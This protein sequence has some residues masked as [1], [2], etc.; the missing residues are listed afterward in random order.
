MEEASSQSL[1]TLNDCLHMGSDTAEELERQAESLDR[2]ERCLD[3]M[4]V[5]LDQSKKHMRQIKS[6]FGGIGNYFARRKKVEEVTDP[7]LPKGSSQGSQKSQSSASSAP[8]PSMNELQGT[9]NVTVDRNCTEMSKALYQ[10]KGMGELI[11]EQ[12]NDSSAQIDRIQYKVERT[13]TKIKGVNKDI[14]RQL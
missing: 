4:H 12:L 8:P 7:K 13:D 9:G 10:L 6:P 5:E 14:R 3:E 1:R 11:G 2:T